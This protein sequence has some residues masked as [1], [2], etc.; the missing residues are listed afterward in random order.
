M[1]DKFYQSLTEDTALRVLSLSAAIYA[2]LFSLWC[3]LKY[4]SFAYYDF[5]LAIHDQVIWNIGRGSAYSSIL[6]INFLGN[7]I[8]FISFLIAPIYKVFNHPLA[9]LFL[10]TIV[11][12]LAVF[13]LYKT[14]KIF[15]GYRLAL[16]VGI[17]YLLY[18]G[19]GYTNLFEFHPTVFATFFLAWM[20]YY[21]YRC[22]TGLFVLFMLLSM[23]CQEN[24][25]LIIIAL[26]IYG[27]CSKRNRLCALIALASGLVYF[28][29]CIKILLPYFN[30]DTIQFIRIYGKLG[31][32]F[33]EIL[34]TIFTR[35]WEVFHIIVQPKKILYLKDIFLPLSFVPLLS[36]LTLLPSLPLLAQHLLSQRGSEITLYYHYTAELIS[37][38]FLAFIGG[39]ARARN[40]V[41]FKSREWFLT[42][43]LLLMALISNII[44]G[45]HFAFFKQYK[46][47]IPDYRDAQKVMLINK[48]PQDASAVSTFEFLSH[49]SHRTDLYSFHHVYSGF[50]TLSMKPYHLPGDV[51][52]ALI[53][54]D[55]FLTFR[56]FYDLY[57]YQ[58]IDEFL[59]QGRWGVL[60]VTDTMVLFKKGIADQHPLFTFIEDF[61][62]PS[63]QVSFIIDDR[64]QWYGYDFYEQPQHIR[65]VFYWRPLKSV[66]K[67]INI[68]IDFM[69]QEGE[70]VYRQYR[71]LCY[72]IWPTQAWKKAQNIQEYQYISIPPHLQG[73]IKRLMVGFYD[74]NTGQRLKTTSKDFL[75]RIEIGPINKAMEAYVQ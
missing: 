43:I 1:L 29:V 56:G 20:F 74:Y 60:D 50:F 55:D 16:V 51:Q 31:N 41:F 66:N 19:L 9:L 23:L 70:V 34:K 6:G 68:F 30:R 35:P 69:D 37:P 61:V 75:G 72:R 22:E 36:P 18:P 2:L 15:L 21:F 62:K 33:T 27:L 54:F 28:I 46:T 25:A 65:L 63:Q 5:D 24:I 40:I 7:H 13:P 71:P 8:H 39:I 32:S 14:A 64:F 3:Y 58:K 44:L 53:D 10:Q 49:L 57:N 38:L 48:I 12:V 26:G 42:G 4:I 47:L 17:I 52:Y 45:P 59:K 67:D 11:L 73:H